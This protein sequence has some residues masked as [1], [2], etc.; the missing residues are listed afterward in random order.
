[1]FSRVTKTSREVDRYTRGMLHYRRGRYSRA[2]ELLGPLEDQPGPLGQVARYYIAMAN[3]ALGMGAMRVGDY[4]S[5]ERYLRTAVRTIG[6]KADLA[7]YLGVCYAKNEQFDRCAVELEKVARRKGRADAWREL[8][9][10]QWRGGRREEAFLTLGGALR[11]FPYEGCLHLQL[12]LFHAA[13]ERYDEAREC[14]DR[15]VENDCDN[16]VA[17]HYLGLVAAAQGDVSGALGCFQRAMDLS[18]DNLLLAHQLSLAVQAADQAGM[19]FVLHLPE[20]TLY[21][22][23]SH[24]RQLAHY[25]TM[26]PDFLDAMLSLPRSEI[27]SDLFSVLASVLELALAR[28][29]NY[30]DLHYYAGG[31]FH[32]LGDVATATQH[33]REALSINP[34][35]VKARMQLANLCAQAGQTR[36]AARHLEQAIECGVDWPDVHFRAGELLLKCDRAKEAQRHFLCALQL[37]PN[38]MRASEALA[39]AAA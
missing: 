22:G 3:R 13:E 36:Q 33:A 38:Y 12:G 14:L 9:Q 4:I 30:A 16:T 8:A 15:A 27:D 7:A 19:H 31:V 2:I 32:R 28:H 26:E 37:K 39:S 35:Y 21:Q 18:L 6:P 17:H 24:A 11:K 1:M 10:A 25:V 34:D 29:A 5:A 20:P 23:N